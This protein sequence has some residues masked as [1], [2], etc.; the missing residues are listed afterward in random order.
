MPLV[1]LLCTF[2]AACEWVPVRTFDRS[3]LHSMSIHHLTR[4]GTDGYATT[5]A[6]GRFTARA[7]RTNVG[8]NTR[9]LFYPGDQP[10]TTDHQSCATWQSQ[11][12]AGVQQGLALRI[13]HDVA[14]HR[15]RAITVTK[16]VVWG[17]NWQLNVTTWDSHRLGWQM[18]GSVNL[19]PVFWPDRELAPLPWR[20]C[21]RVEGDLVRVKGWRVGTP[22]PSWTDPVHSGTVR[23]PAD[24]VYRGKAG[25]YVGHL[26]PGQSTVMTDLVLDRLELR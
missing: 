15:W 9:I 3:S 26:A 7:P 8:T 6:P 17:A 11:D 21:G 20:V 14:Q 18:H 22:E 24:W 19:A 23:V 25:W 16:N 13:R 12:G 4:D 2:V 5:A 1:V 10:V